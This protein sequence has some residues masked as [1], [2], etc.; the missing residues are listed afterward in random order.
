MFFKW[1]KSLFISIRGGVGDSADFS[2]M[3]LPCSSIWDRNE[4]STGSSRFLLPGLLKVLRLNTFWV[5]GDLFG[6][7]ELFWL[8]EGEPNCY[9]SM[10]MGEEAPLISYIGRIGLS[11]ATSSSGLSSTFLMVG[12]LTGEKFEI[13]AYGVA[14]WVMLNWGFNISAGAW[15]CFGKLSCL[16][17]VGVST[18]AELYTPIGL[19][20]GSSSIGP[21]IL[22]LS[23]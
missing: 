22:S 3:T 7:K 16:L 6:L 13:W 20:S 10:D 12:S 9:W 11:G 5:S 15:A 14:F 4:F 19:Y 1:P 18:S 23:S 17:R 21:S 8:F 2:E